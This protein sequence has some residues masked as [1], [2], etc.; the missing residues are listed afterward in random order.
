MSINRDEIIQAQKTWGDGIVAIG[1]AFTEGRDY[2]QRAR[3]HINQLYAY[4]LGNVLFKPTQASQKQ[5]RNTAEEAESYFIGKSGV[6]PEDQ[7][8]ALRPWTR[9][10]FENAGMLL[11]GDVALC[12]GNYFFTDTQ[13]QET[14]VEYTFGYVKTADGGV[15]IILHHSSLPYSPP[16]D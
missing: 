11:L 4:D 3:Q 7:G 9:V 8:F 1:S 12:M 5:F 15:K 14:K 2:V 10:H 16:D 6:C 13:G